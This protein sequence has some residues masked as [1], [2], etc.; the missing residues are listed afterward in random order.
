MPDFFIDLSWIVALFSFAGLCGAITKW[1][2]AGPEFH[3]YHIT[4]TYAEYDEHVL[5]D[6]EED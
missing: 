2:W 3:V 6:G 4:L 5:A 1:L